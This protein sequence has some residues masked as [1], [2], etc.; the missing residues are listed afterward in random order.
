MTMPTKV[1]IRVTIERE[2]EEPN[3]L[4]MEYEDAVICQE[5]GYI[6]TYP[7]FGRE[8]PD[9]ASNG[10]GRMSI[11]AWKGCA[12]YDSFVS[13]EQRIKLPPVPG[14]S[15]ETIRRL[16]KAGTFISKEKEINE[17]QDR[18]H[19]KGDCGEAQ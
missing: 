19:G 16:E 17:K 18:E 10:H 4:E 1:K 7:V 14:V 9:I 5:R 12:S 13:H 11:K 6:H 15:Q 2:G 8:R 3:V